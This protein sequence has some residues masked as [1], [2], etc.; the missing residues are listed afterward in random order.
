M[1]GGHEPGNTGYLKKFEN[2]K[3]PINPPEETDP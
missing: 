3:N 1:E 2:A